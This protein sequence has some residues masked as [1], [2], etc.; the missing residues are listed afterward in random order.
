M[1]KF[2]MWL[3]AFFTYFGIIAMYLKDPLGLSIAFVVISAIRA[4]ENDRR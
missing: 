2:L 1:L 4:Y 3:A